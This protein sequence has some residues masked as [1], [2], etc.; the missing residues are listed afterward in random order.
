MNYNHG[1]NILRLFGILPNF[2]FTTSKTKRDYY[3]QTCYIQAAS[4]VAQ[5][6]KNED[7]RKIGNTRNISKP[8]RLIA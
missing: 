7:L 3:Q 6:H 8:Q 2:T 1:H 5:R 4:G